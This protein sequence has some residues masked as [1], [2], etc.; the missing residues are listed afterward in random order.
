MKAIVMT[1]VG[2]IE[3]LELREL[4]SPTIERD[5]QILIKLKAAG[6]NPVD[7]K[8]RARGTYCPQQLPTILGCDGAGIV[9]RIG[10]AV[11]RFQPGD[12]VFFCFG[13]IGCHSGNYADYVVIEE[14]CAA[15]KPTIWNFFTAA[16]APLVCITAWEAL[17]DRGRLTPASMVL[18]HAGA[19][20]VG[21]VAIQLAVAAGARV[22]TTVSDQAKAEF[23][24]KLG[25]ERVI[26]YRE[27]NFVEE[28]LSWTNG[29]GVDLAFDTVGGSTFAATFGAVKIYGDLVTILQPGLDVDWTIARSRN[30]RISLELMLTPMHLNWHD[31]LQHQGEILAHCANLALNGKLQIHVANLLPLVEAATAHQLIQAGGMMGKIVLNPEYN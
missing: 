26:I 17:Y 13:G 14:A 5:T 16:A 6:V 20:G 8:L 4:P 19:G 27:Q 24:Q 22:I 25:A 30:L 2:G 15:F 12:E 29:K 7:T 1:A 18:I 23:V 10:A 11:T 3:V 28:V 9:E 31:G 21:H